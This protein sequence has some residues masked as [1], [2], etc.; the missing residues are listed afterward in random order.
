VALDVLHKH[1]DRQPKT[2]K[3]YF[4]YIELDEVMMAN[5]KLCTTIYGFNAFFFFF[6]SSTF[7]INPCSATSKEYLKIHIQIVELRL[8]INKDAFRP[9]KS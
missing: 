3:D 1:P 9:E 7:D 4:R 8:P 2:G 5:P 6:R